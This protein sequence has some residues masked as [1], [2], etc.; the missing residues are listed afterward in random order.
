MAIPP[1]LKYPY[2]VDDIHKR[3]QNFYQKT[4]GNSKQP[5]Q[6][7]Q[8]QSQFSRSSRASIHQQQIL[9]EGHLGHL[10]IYNSNIDIKYLGLSL[11][12]KVKHLYYK[13]FKQLKKYLE[14]HKNIEGILCSWI[15]KIN[16]VKITILP[17]AANA[18]TIKMHHSSRN[19]RY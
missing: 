13:N 9:R 8:M 1:K 19:E 16:I 4:S 6:R 5:Q 2:L 10:P 18:I 15:G 14:R 12:Q 3:L 11:I 7:S 17:K